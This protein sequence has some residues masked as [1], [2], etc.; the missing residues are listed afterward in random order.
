MNALTPSQQRCL[1]SLQQQAQQD[2]FLGTADQSP[3]LEQ[4]LSELDA[5]LQRDEADA[6]QRL[7]DISRGIGIHAESLTGMLR[8]LRSPLEQALG[9]LQQDSS[10]A[11][12]DTAMSALST[13]SEALARQLRHRLLHLLDDAAPS[14]DIVPALL[15]MVTVGRDAA[16]QT[17]PESLWLL[18]T[19]R[20]NDRLQPGQSLAEQFLTPALESLCQSPW[21]ARWR[22]R[23]LRRRLRIHFQL[24]EIDLREAMEDALLRRSD[25]SLAALAQRHLDTHTTLDTQLNDAWRALRYAIDTALV[26]L[27]DLQ[28]AP[29]DPQSGTLSTKVAELTTLITQ[30]FDKTGDVL[31][32]S[33]EIYATVFNGLIAELA[34]DREHAFGAA[35]QLLASTD[36]TTARWRYAWK[37]LRKNVR[38]RAHKW[39]E[40]GAASLPLAQ[41][42]FMRVRRRG[43][44]AW[45][46]LNELLRLGEAPEE[47]LLAIADLPTERELAEH[48]QTLPP[49]YRRLYS[50]EPL[51]NRE[52]LVGRDDEL[53]T[54]AEAFKRW[55]AKRPANIA[56]IGNEGSGKSSLIN[57]FEN[58]ITDQAEVVHIDLDEHLRTEADVI[59]LF[60]LRL[61]I[62]TTPDSIVGLAQAL[63]DAPRRIVIVHRTHNMYLRTVGGSAAPRAFFRLMLATRVHLMW[64]TSYRLYPWK[65]LDYLFEAGRYYTHQLTTAL[66][67]EA[68]MREAILRRQ[69]TTGDS[70]VFSDEKL[71]NRMIR[72]LRL[73]HELDSPVVQRALADRYFETLFRQ[74]GG[75]LESAFYFW[76]LSLS[77]EGPRQLTVQPS[78]T[79]DD[80]LIRG[81]ERLDQFTLAELLGH[82]HLTATEHAELFRIDPSY[83]RLIIDNLV[84]LRIIVRAG[85]DHSADAA[86]YSV[87]PVFQQTVIGVLTDLNSL[88]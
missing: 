51:L 14:H 86:R 28:A 23:R 1:E 15:D 56:I 73:R 11:A 25:I 19:R 42:L 9:M 71:T 44:H 80:R 88:Y 34:Q 30:A 48:L 41:Q 22:L 68:E 69:R 54:L 36:S 10:P 74:S 53:Q 26:E 85:T 76:L 57:C 24:I 38:R 77:A 46:Q 70:L 58:E 21:L 87:S 59:R 29:P 40:Q 43:E 33:A 83:S 35:R 81:M 18:R 82:G 75:N 20:P 84:Q 49:I 64:L 17:L 65:R 79:L 2:A 61:G 50:T 67:D 31:H 16:V 66:H 60:A 72:K 55:R 32:E 78:L 47:S 12:V 8:E 5:I 62:N 6:G 45:L 39:H 63:L 4:L 27:T 3:R 37:T 13:G 7:L 52:F